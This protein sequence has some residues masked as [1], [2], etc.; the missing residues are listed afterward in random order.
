MEDCPLARC[1]AGAS[2]CLKVETLGDH[3]D[4]VVWH[5][6]V[7][8]ELVTELCCSGDHIIAALGAEAPNTPPDR[9]ESPTAR[10]EV[11]DNLDDRA[12]ERERHC[13]AV[14]DKVRPEAIDGPFCPNPCRSGGKPP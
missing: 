8:H 5:A 11:V 1:E 3:G 12:A 2:I 9:S 10:L 14:D 13:L 4:L 7:A 6:E